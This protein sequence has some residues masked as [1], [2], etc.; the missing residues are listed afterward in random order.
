MYACVYF[1][2]HTIYRRKTLIHRHSYSDECMHNSK[3]MSRMGAKKDRNNIIWYK[4]KE[5]KISQRIMIWHARLSNSK[6]YANSWNNIANHKKK[7]L[8]SKAILK[9][10]CFHR[11]GAQN[12]G[13]QPQIIITNTFKINKSINAAGHHFT[14]MH[15]YSEFSLSL[16]Q[17]NEVQKPQIPRVKEHI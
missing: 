7:I 10:P 12:Q 11:W 3:F 17:G 15:A 6:V 5:N 1:C 9:C 2:S 8:T 4:N 14:Q 13:N 16:N